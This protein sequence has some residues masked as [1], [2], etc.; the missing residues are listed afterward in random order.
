MSREDAITVGTLCSGS[1]G[2]CALFRVGGTAILIDAGRSTKYIHDTLALFGIEPQDIGGIFVT[3]PHTDHVS[4]LR[5]WTKK[6]GTPVHAAGATAYEITD[7]CAPGTLRD[8]PAEFSED[9]G[10]LNIRS[11]PTSH[12]TSC[13]VGYRI[14]VTEGRYAGV[15]FG[16]STDLGCLTEAVAA[17]MAGCRAVILESNHDVEMLLEGPYTPEMKK[18]ILSRRGHLSNPDAA[19]FAVQLAARGTEAI[20]LAHISEINNTPE[21]ALGCAQEA[22]ACA[23]LSPYLYTGAKC[24]PTMMVDI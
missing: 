22:L 19:Q 5:V 3:H 1:S 6:Y 18:R 4:A 24:R 15:A 17:G 12:D 13:S 21:L 16:L 11:F 14:T 20:L 23:G 7:L 10:C 8:H 2:N 9:I